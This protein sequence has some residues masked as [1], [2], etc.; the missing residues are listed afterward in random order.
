MFEDGK[1]VPLTSQRLEKYRQVLRDIRQRK[2]W[3]TTGTGA[4]FTGTYTE[5]DDEAVYISSAEISGIAPYNGGILYAVNIDGVG[6]IYSK[7][8][9]VSAVDEGHIV[10]SNAMSVYSLSVRDDVCAA[11]TGSSGAER[12]ISLFTLPSGRQTELTEGDTKEEYPFYSAVSDK[13]YF[14]VAGFARRQDGS[15]AALSPR[16]VVAYSFSG[17]TMETLLEDENTDY[18]LPKDDAQ[19]NLFYIRRPYKDKPSSKSILLDILMF[20]YRLVK[21]IGGF[22]N[23]FS[24]FFGGEP[25]NSNGTR[26]SA[27]AKQKSEKELFIN[28]NIINAEQTLK[29]NS[30]K[31]DK[32]PG[33]I[34]ASWQLVRRDTQG[35]EV[36]LKSG[37]MDYVVCPNGD[38]VCS[39]GKAL[40]RIKPDGSE[41]LLVKVKLAQ[42]LICG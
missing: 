3:K 38:I 22:L 11:C 33:I 10:S 35:K 5:H 17:G 16:S 26:N 20:P 41:E 40:I 30:R 28:G 1:A 24:M 4:R 25:L 8:P 21:A 34:P 37:V 36:C 9:D 13:L 12:H 2:E 7:A 39:N 14:T 6:G 15:I 19:G 32:H 42:N 31:G 18:F 23:V 27:K 29:E